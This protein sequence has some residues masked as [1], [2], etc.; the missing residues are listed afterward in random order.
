M[1]SRHLKYDTQPSN[2]GA[3]G[4][5]MLSIG[6]LTNRKIESLYKILYEKMTFINMHLC[7]NTHEDDLGDFR[8]FGW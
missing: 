2:D 1:H 5:L 6:M 4:I 7:I 3:E 8:N